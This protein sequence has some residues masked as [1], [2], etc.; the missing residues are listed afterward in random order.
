MSD[1]PREQEVSSEQGAHAQAESAPWGEVKS[2]LGEAIELSGH[3]RQR[4]LSALDIQQPQVA[5]RVRS[6]LDAHQASGDFLERSPATMRLMSDEAW[7]GRRVG[8]YR[9]YR[10]AAEGGMGRVFR[11]RRDDGAFEREVAVKVVAGG[12]SWLNDLDRRLARERQIVASLEHPAIAQLLDGGTTE[13][14]FAFLVLEWVDGLRIDRWCDQLRLTIGERLGLLTSVCDA[15]AAAHSKMVV[16]GDLKPSNLL[17]QPDG[18]VK[19]LDFGIA[20]LL[21][22][23]PDNESGAFPIPGRT[24]SPQLAEDGGDG[25]DLD[26]AS[27]ESTTPTPFTPHYASPEQQQGKTVDT[28]SDVY[29]LGVVAHLLLTG[30]LPRATAAAP[31]AE[32]AHQATKSD[33]A[34]ATYSR[35]RRTT[36][37]KL[38]RRLT[39]DIDAVVARALA[40]SPADRYPSVR[41]LAQDL[42]NVIDNRPVAAR[43]APLRHRVG[44]WVARSPWLATAT[45]GLVVA[46]LGLGVMSQRLVHERRVALEQREAAEEVANF[47]VDLFE[48]VDRADA[49]AEVSAKTLIEQGEQRLVDRLHERPRMRAR[50]LHTLGTAAYRIGLDSKAEVLWQEAVELRRDLA[51]QAEISKPLVTRE[52][53]DHDTAESLIAL[54]NVAVR[55]RAADQAEPLLIEAVERLQQALTS[56]RLHPDAE[57]TLAEAES[58][59]G[60]VNLRLNRSQTADQLTQQALERCRASQ[61]TIDDRPGCWNLVGARVRSNRAGVLLFT[62]RPEEALPMLDEARQI[63]S[64]LLGEQH[65]GVARLD[66]NRAL[67]R[68]SVGEVETALKI[69][70]Q[71]TQ[72]LA[73]RLGR[74]HPQTMSAQNLLINGYAAAGLDRAA[75]RALIPIWESAEQ[76]RSRARNDGQSHELNSEQIWTRR[77]LGY[78]HA[79]LGDVEASQLLLDEELE[80]LASLDGPSAQ[81]SGVKDGNHPSLSEPRLPPEDARRVGEWRITL[82]GARGNFGGALHLAQQLNGLGPERDVNDQELELLAASEL[83]NGMWT[84]ARSRTIEVRDGYRDTYPAASLIHLWPLMYLCQLDLLAGQPALALQRLNAIQEPLPNIPDGSWLEPGLEVLRAAAVG[85]IARAQ[86]AQQR[87]EQALTPQAVETRRLARVLAHLSAGEQSTVH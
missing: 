17:V 81:R 13:D 19:L 39:G 4:F 83:D 43:E 30:I 45:A 75:R 33:T 24:Q 6:L 3:E 41:A 16:H 52:E 18:R 61:P 21:S 5:Q 71:S 47:T 25:A 50:L 69:L 74:Q 27:L 38:L 57:L 42:Q 55:D 15:V 87:V 51:E 76:E 36:P 23:L 56:P 26:S 32:V 68:F 11:A 67:I 60:L 48:V 77:F 7:L 49:A 29:S 40:Q 53:L 8:A 14:G 22:A 84:E 31:S 20:E 82:E 35:D 85:D 79:A 63:T 64:L 59:L 2:A 58:S 37:R 78:L 28:L 72:Q 1:Q 12:A 80:Y 66:Q 54:A 70:E 73:E 34:I 62:G 46:T 44:L 65:A 10:K 86:V 9:I